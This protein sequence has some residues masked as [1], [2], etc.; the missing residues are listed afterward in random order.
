M[1]EIIQVNIINSM[2]KGSHYNTEFCTAKHV[3]Q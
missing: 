3:P 2:F 1:G